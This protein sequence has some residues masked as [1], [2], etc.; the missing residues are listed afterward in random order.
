MTHTSTR[1][2]PPVFVI[3]ACVLSAVVFGFICWNSTLRSD[4]EPTT[5]DYLFLLLYQC[6]S[7]I[8]YLVTLWYFG[9]LSDFH[10]TET[11]VVLFLIS[12]FGTIVPFV[13]SSVQ[14]WTTHQLELGSFL[15]QSAV[16]WL[17]LNVVMLVMMAVTS[18]VGFLLTLPF[19]NGARNVAGN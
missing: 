8:S 12:V 9:R 3:V 16:A 19:R 15:R 7:L 18:T 1:Q 13:A 11:I 17:L 6:L 4:A 2:R 10:G 5:R 14:I